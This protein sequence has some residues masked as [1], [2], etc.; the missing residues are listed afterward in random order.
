M[1]GAMYRG[2]R[3]YVVCCVLYVRNMAVVKFGQ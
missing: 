3:L 2:L 1:L